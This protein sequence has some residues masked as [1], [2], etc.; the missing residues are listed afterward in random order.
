MR[1]IEG[2]RVW[3]GIRDVGVS[4]LSWLPDRIE[5]VTPAAEDRFP[6]LC[7]IPG[8]VDTHVHL[9]GSAHD[10]GDTFT[11]P[12]VTRREEQTLHA[13]ANAQ[14]AMRN[15]V[16][17]LRD[18]AGD[19]AQVAVRR[20]FDLGIMPGPRVLVSGPV[21]MTAGHGD[22]FLPPAV[23]E[24]APLADSPDECRKLVRTWAR[25]GVTGI[26]IFTSGGVLSIGDK[27]GWR[28]HTRAELAATV[29]EAHALGMLV[30]A[31]A[32]S[33]VGIQIAMEEG[34]D[35]IEHGTELT[36]AQ[37]E[38]LAARGTPVGPTL[39]INEI[40]AQ[41]KAPASAEAREKAAEL[42]ARR[43][44]LF[45]SAARTGVR[46]VLATDASGYFVR[47]GD[48]MSEVVRM[49]EVLGISA[50][51]ALRAATSDAAASIGLGD[52]TGSL[53]PGLGADFVVLRGRPWAR[54]EDLRPETI[55]AVVSRGEVV[56][57]RL[58]G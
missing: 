44:D 2:I 53:T 40:I 17:T 38:I 41:G 15:G 8:L 31:H 14:R 52:V 5:E 39:L 34:A 13:A 11:W 36:A 10:D 20:A 58:P 7:V 46:F 57:G 50:E 23:R 30:S 6:E 43:D 35:S 19:E 48:Q 42:V 26:K 54:I 3:D 12:L 9:L 45:R 16:T 22:L 28:N 49:T 55:V 4:R 51:A 33:E 21:G 37:A 56:A 24:R 47:F 29:D 32:H 25:A 27:V 18:L 1:A